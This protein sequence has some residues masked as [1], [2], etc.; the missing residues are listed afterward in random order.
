MY[1]SNA[2]L[3]THNWDVMR[4]NLE[5]FATE[6]KDTPGAGD[7]MMSFFRG[8]CTHVLDKDGKCSL[9]DHKEEKP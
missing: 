7:A 1:C 4:N 9:C 6:H 3:T 2:R 8:E 5:D